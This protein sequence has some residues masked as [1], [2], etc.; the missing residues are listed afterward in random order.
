MMRQGRSLAAAAALS[1]LMA[2]M[3]TVAVP[4]GAAM[5]AAPGPTL[6]SGPSV[7]LAGPAPV[8]PAGSAVE[9]PSEPS[10]TLTVDLAL[11]P[12]DPAALNAFVAAVSTPGSPRY[13][14]Y[15]AAGQFASTF[16][17][18]P[19]TVEATR[20]WLSSTGLRPGTT[21]PDGLL[22]PVSGSAAQLE[23][24]LGVSL[25]TTRL[26]DG[27]VA[28]FAP[29]QPS[30]PS[31]LAPS[32][33]GVVGLSTVAAPQPQL[34]PST[35]PGTVASTSAPAGPAPAA[36]AATGPG[37]CSSAAGIGG[38][39]AGQLAAAYGLDSLYRSGLDGTGQTIGIYELEPYT[40]SDIGT[41]E[42]CYGITTSVTDTPVDGGPST[43]DQQGE[44]ALDI[45]DAI[46]LAPRAS[47][48]VFTG[49]QIGPGASDTGPIDTY[50]AMV[51]D[52]S[53]KVISTSWGLC[54]PQMAGQGD[55]QLVESFLF[56]EAAAQGQTVVA[57]SGDSGSTDCYSPTQ[58]SATAVTVDDPADQPDVT[59]VGGS[60]LL[61][62]GSPPAETG[63]NDF[64]GSGGG[65]VSSD[66]DQP[67]WQS[68]PGVDAAAAVTQCA[69]LGRTSCREVPDVAASSDPAHGYAIYCTAPASPVACGSQRGWFAVGGTSGAAPLW[70][71]LLAVIDQGLP[72]PAGLINPVL[73][74]A[75]SCAASPF[76]DITTGS[77]AFLAVSQ[78][79][80]PATAHY[81]VATGWGSP[82][83]PGLLADLASPPTCPTVTGVQPAK[84]PVVGGNSV[85]V[86]GSGFGAA[87]SVRFGGT[88]APFTV[89]SST[90]LV[91]RVPSGPA[92][93]A[94]VDVSVADSQ[95]SSPLVA[96]DRY[97][98]APPGYWL[99]AS[100]GGIF[101]FGHAAFSGSTGG[102]HLNQPIVGMAPSSDDGGY[103]LVASDGGIFAF[104]DAGF[105]G[106]TGG[107]H[108][109]QPI[110]GMAATPS[111][112]GYWLVASD[113]GIFA[114]GDA[115]FYG[116]TGG[117]HL[118]QPI[119]GMAATPS[120]HGYWLVARDGGIFAFG[121]AT[122]RGS[123]GGMHLNRPIVGMGA[124]PT[125]GGYWLVA[126]DGGIFTFG[127]AVF[128]GGT[129]GQHLNQP[130]VGMAVDLTGGGYWL[131]AS[132]GGIFA[133]GAAGFS[134]S[135]GG[136][137][138]NQPI[139]G[140]A[141]T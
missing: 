92:A 112:G 122:F 40:P 128:H 126:S 42:S 58:P 125:G 137:H 50:E 14:R 17:P 74:A 123:T 68:G 66:F 141:A 110:V 45:E 115:G 10:T 79:R 4:V 134:G 80:Y 25:V 27:R 140:M 106:S 64:F 114:F 91:A 71:A 86:T 37:S 49:P 119:V 117:M 38:Y 129:G 12:R 100:D 78:G 16:G 55:Q 82:T 124:D 133:F 67:S 93:G 30:V 111:G 83:A 101:T 33:A 75:G 116:S 36:V 34:V 138:L 9:G 57:A 130:I 6:G 107:M 44:A 15:L 60:S 87:T 98:F 53:L 31:G 109:N 89:T 88:P 127:D 29:E 26:A 104:G 48:K 118:N 73:Y 22:I 51:A 63:W 24:A 8:L 62:V 21:S 61:S 103:W 121:D 81:D 20:G 54:E 11:R 7:R 19:A 99:V 1:C 39:T 52:S 90:T 59:G 43:T 97:T 3:V 41:Y 70:A 18:A 13:H 5:A 76:N 105:Y 2:G 113:G 56:A 46:G 96:A 85:T 131:V 120:G 136:M 72:G 84:G 139:V 69:A 65:G 47:V 77:N 95:G 32:V 23:A 135:T 94:T 28:R 35:G 102:M 108:L 132:D